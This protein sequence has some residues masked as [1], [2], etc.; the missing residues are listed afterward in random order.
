MSTHQLVSAY[1]TAMAASDAKAE[2]EIFYK[3]ANSPTD[4][5]GW[6]EIHGWAPLGSDLQ[7][8]A[9]TKMVELA[10]TF[11]EWEAVYA[12]VPTGSDQSRIALEK[13]RQFHGE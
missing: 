5:A 13:I 10:S 12:I 7:A 8:L 11:S 2:K 3:I 1:A 9:V 4:F 6:R